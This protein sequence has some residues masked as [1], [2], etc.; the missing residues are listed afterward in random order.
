MKI[1]QFLTIKNIDKFMYLNDF[2]IR[3]F[4]VIKIKNIVG[5]LPVCKKKSLNFSIPY[6]SYGLYYLEEI[7]DEVIKQL[8]F[9][10]KS[11]IQKF[12]IKVV[13]ICIILIII[14]KYQL[15]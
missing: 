3:Y 15:F 6:F 1:F 12:Y 5:F 13:F 7:N 8:D 14:I 9:L 10:I 2:K 11:K 4:F